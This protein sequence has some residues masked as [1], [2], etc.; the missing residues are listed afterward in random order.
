MPLITSDDIIETYSKLQQRGANFI[1]SKFNLNGRSRTLSAFDDHNIEA[2]NWWNI[3][4]IKERWNEKI[5]GDKKVSYENHVLNTYYTSDKDLKML[6]IGAGICS[7]EF[8]FAKTS[9]FS[10]ILCVDIAET[11]LVQAEQRARKENIKSIEF[12]VADVFQ[13]D[14]QNHQFD[15]ILF[16][17]SLHH[18]KEIKTLLS[19]VQQWLKPSG[20][21]I[22]N[23]Y[24]GPNRLQFP[25]KQIHAINELL[26]HIP[27]KWRK[28]FKTDVLKKRVSGPGKI[29]MIL[30]DPSECVNSNSIVGLI[31]KQ[32]GVVEEKKIGG[33]LLALG[34]KDIAH[35]FYILDEEKS[36]L[37]ERIFTIEDEYLKEHESDYLFGIYSN[38]AF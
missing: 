30:A 2:S 1:F 16:H 34:L 29:R 21:L 20:R 18:F 36:K 7:H 5:S 38:E 31:H 23:E 14:L 24:V 22:I 3:P 26:S 12:R 28:R 32:F 11:L 10:Q 9:K 25:K 19:K 35:H 33:N 37:L 6:S 4:A 15:I 27:N 13:L 17:M 8:N